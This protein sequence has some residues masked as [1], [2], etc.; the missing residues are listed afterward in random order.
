MTENQ[1]P[2]K[3][4]K[5]SP[6]KHE[7]QSLLDG[8]FPSGWVL[9][10]AV[11][12]IV[13]S[14]V[15]SGWKIVNLEQEKQ[16][17]SIAR[18]LLE[19]DRQQLEIDI[20]T[21][22]KILKELPGI[23]TQTDDLSRQKNALIGE[24]NAARKQLED[25]NNLKQE[26]L[27]R[28]NQAAAEQSHAVAEKTASMEIHTRYSNE[29]SSLRE[30][31]EQFERQTL[32]LKD[33]LQN[34]QTELSKL[35]T[36]EAQRN[37]DVA[38][39]ERRKGN[40]EKDLTRIAEE[41]GRLDNIS[42]RFDLLAGKLEQTGLQ[43]NQ[44]LEL[45]QTS[46]RNF[47]A[48]LIK[49][50]DD[51][52]QFASHSKSVGTLSENLKTTSETLDAT[53]SVLETTAGGMQNIG[54]HIEGAAS[55]LGTAIE[56]TDRQAKKLA[57]L[58]QKPVQSIADQAGTLSTTISQMGKQLDLLPGQLS[59]LNTRIVE[60]ENKTSSFQEV[61]G[62]LSRTTEN[63]NTANLNVGSAAKTL[64]DENNNVKAQSVE[65]EKLV[66]QVQTQ[67]LPQ[68]NSIKTDLTEMSRLIN[69]MVQRLGQ[70]ET[71]IRSLEEAKPK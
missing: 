53:K 7:G 32:A 36:Q 46:G 10:A 51:E 18:I 58:L 33:E 66:S 16:E 41:K 38:G 4:E 11:L 30:K 39:L 62:Q 17:V 12:L 5:S 47:D 52:E 24:V 22:E 19:K 9:A 54:K 71:H 20:A 26:A 65:L 49:I 6:P 70:I 44:N 56:G 3:G 8:L 25:L 59:Q 37:A 35:Q 13:V 67:L 43:A 31:K 14:M 2:M 45:I 48:L 15:L 34:L 68:S 28:L 55:Q 27:D 61:I 69:D 63:L 29:I 64:A 50:S 23:K 57:E 40:L 1:S 42:A 21:H 60:L